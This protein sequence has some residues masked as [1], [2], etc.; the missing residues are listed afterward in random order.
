MSAYVALLRGINLASRNRIP[1][2]E[3]REA[4]TGDELRNV[5]TLLQSGNVVLS[6]EGSADDVAS[7]CE[8]R[9]SAR[10]GLDIRVIVRSRDEL[11]E[12]VARNPLEGVASEP[13]RYQVTFLSAELEPKRKDEVEAAAVPPE[14][15]VVSGREIYAWHPA[16]LAHSKL[17]SLLAG[18][19][20]GVPATA[21][22]W[23]TVTKL[24]ELA[25]EQPS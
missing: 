16:G 19:K 9:I 14:R 20:L 5:R 21:C 11:T 24:L 2:A 4:L 18:K 25:D 13:K 17:A 8:R 15:V 3:L 7:E 23:S 22:N 10:F 12:V 1:M 6:A